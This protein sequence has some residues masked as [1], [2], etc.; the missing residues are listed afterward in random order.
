MSGSCSHPAVR[1]RDV[2]VR[3]AKKIMVDLLELKCLAS[4]EGVT[5]IERIRYTVGIASVE[6]V[7]AHE[8]D[9]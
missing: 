8:E 6:V 9:K 5:R 4:M 3:E 2:A 1:G 7:R